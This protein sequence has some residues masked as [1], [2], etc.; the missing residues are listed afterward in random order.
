MVSSQFC[1]SQF[2]PPRNIGNSGGRECARRLELTVYAIEEWV[3]VFMFDLTR[4]RLTDRSNARS[5][6]DETCLM[7]LSTIVARTSSTDD[8]FQQ[9]F[10]KVSGILNEP[11]AKTATHEE[12]QNNL[13]FLCD[14]DS[15]EEP[16]RILFRSRDA[17]RETHPVVCVIHGQVKEAHRELVSRLAKVS[18][19][20]CL[21]VS[22]PLGSPRHI[23]IPFQVSARSQAEFDQSFSER[24]ASVL[25]LPGQSS[26]SRI[27]EVL[28]QHRGA[29]FVDLKVRTKELVEDFV[30]T[31]F[32]FFGQPEC[33]FWT[34]PE[35]ASDGNTKSL[36]RKEEDAS[37]TSAVHGGV[38]V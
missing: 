19:P 15:Q 22:K 11:L 35:K 33:L 26:P 5:R 31:C 29:V 18:L 1:G 9:P 13:S 21:Q 2:C 4:G 12:A 30:L 20:E 32:R 3:W 34:Q 37:A 8:L 25:N 27:Q 14:R 24:L 23:L 16:F 28:K 17:E 7:C 10:E 36:G 38:Q 6:G